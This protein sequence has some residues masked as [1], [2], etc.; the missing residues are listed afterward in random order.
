MRNV[1]IILGKICSAH[2]VKGNFKFIPY[3]LDFYNNI[4]NYK[5]L[6]YINDHKIN[7]IILFRKQNFLVCKSNLF[8][9]KEDL[10]YYIGKEIWTHSINIKTSNNN[11]YFHKDLINCIV[12]D[13]NK[14]KL[15]LVK[16]IHNF[17][18]GDLLELDGS[19][20]F[21]IRFYDIEEHNI[22]IIN[23]VILLSNKYEF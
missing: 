15:G 19:F 4:C 23:K 17:G 11:E 21:M 3:N 9:T 16:A 5:N 20:K 13:Q 6:L 22:D 2:G 18:A 8:S 12:Y 10:E 14:K 1:K 7:L